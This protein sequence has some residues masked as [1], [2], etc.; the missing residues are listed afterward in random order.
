MTID[1]NK[2]PKFPGWVPLGPD[3][4]SIEGD[5]LVAYKGCFSEISDGNPETSTNKLIKGTSSWAFHGGKS[6]NQEIKNKEIN[7]DFYPYRRKL[8]LN[9][10]H[11][12]PA[13]L[14]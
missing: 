9:A 4:P 11:S 5:V 1:L 12:E 6:W 7:P 14:P 13:P 2:L 3:E 8:T 10:F